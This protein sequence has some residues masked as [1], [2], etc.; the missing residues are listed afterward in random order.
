MLLRGLAMFAVVSAFGMG[1]GGAEVP[2]EAEQLGQD[3]AALLQSCE[4]LQTRRCTPDAEVGCQWADGAYGD[5][6]CQNIPFNT[7]VC[8]RE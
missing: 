7:W 6:F 4:T 5:C 8:L 3:S 2:E 1:C